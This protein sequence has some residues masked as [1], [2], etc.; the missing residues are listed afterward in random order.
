MVSCITFIPLFKCHP[1]VGIFPGLPACLSVTSVAV[2]PSRKLL[3][4]STLNGSFSRPL[5]FYRPRGT[6][7]LSNSSWFSVLTSVEEATVKRTKL[8]PG[9]VSVHNPAPC[10]MCVFP[11]VYKR[12][13]TCCFS[14]VLCVIHFL[15]HVN[16]TI[17]LVILLLNK[18]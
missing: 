14:I 17:T 9:C 13:Y 18:S 8:L 16:A 1:W 12:I 4:A 2:L 3:Q 15:I 10:L 7:S 5:S 11:K 6:H